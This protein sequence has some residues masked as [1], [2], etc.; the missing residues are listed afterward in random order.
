[1]TTYAS[2]TRD[3]AEPLK[4]IAHGKR[5]TQ[6]ISLISSP[7]KTDTVLDY[8][9]GDG[10]LFSHFLGNIGRTKLV[11]YDPDPKLIAEASA[12]VAAGSTLTSDIEALKQQHKSAFSL[13]YCM[14]VCE[15]LTDKA[16][17]QLFSNIKAMSAPDARI[18][19]GIPIETGLSGFLKSI[20]RMA[21]GGRQNANIMSAFKSLFGIKI[22]R[23]T[24]DVEW[25]GPH[26]GFNHQRLRGRL[27]SNGFMVRRSHCLP[28]P[29]LGSVLNN[30]IYFV[31]SIK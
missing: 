2:Y 31:C 29:T 7:L 11:G 26:T 12:E 18:V 6:V 27:E 14:E 23:H 20:Y 28:F 1:M 16:L 17:D 25:Y 30:E 3:T 15:H 13:I 19:F 9:C 24:T 21:H 8:G 5:F 4:R 22:D 10:H